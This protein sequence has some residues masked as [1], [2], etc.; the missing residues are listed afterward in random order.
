[1]QSKDRAGRAEYPRYDPH[2]TPPPPAPG[3]YV[4]VFCRFMNKT[5]EV[6]PGW[7]ISHATSSTA[8]QT[9]VA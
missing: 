5:F 7:H 3:D 1:V 4:D 9:L 2:F 6:G 8:L